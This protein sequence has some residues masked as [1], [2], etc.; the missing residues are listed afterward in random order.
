MLRQLINIIPIRVGG[1]RQ[2]DQVGKYYVNRRDPGSGIVL[3]GDLLENVK[4]SWWGFSRRIPQ[5]A[6]LMRDRHDDYN[7][8]VVGRPLN[9]NN[10]RR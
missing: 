4:E 1:R 5:D 3:L 7:G 10:E 6:V 8:N 2:E 9:R